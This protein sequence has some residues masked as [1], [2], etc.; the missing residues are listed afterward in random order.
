VRP[1]WI[2]QEDIEGIDSEP[3]IA[4]VVAQGMAVKRFKH[5]TRT[6]IDFSGY[7]PKACILCYGDIDFVHQAYNRAPFVPGVWCNFSNMKCSKYYTYLGEHLLNQQYIIM[8]IGELLR[9]W[10]GLT[11]D[12][13]ETSGI[14]KRS[15][16]VRP[17]SGAKPFTGHIIKYDEYHKIQSLIQ[18]IGPETLVIVAPEKQITAEWRFVICDKKVVTG[19][20]YLPVEC[21]LT[22][23]FIRINQPSSFSLATAIAS[24]EWQP[25]L[26]YTVDIAE[27]EGDVHLLEINSF[28][29][30]G[31]YCCDI[32]SIVRNAS[33]VAAKEWK[34]YYD[35]NE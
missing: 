8:P 11:T 33:E 3:L 31:F 14:F 6:E 30:A 34:D 16:F 1:A 22:H 13:S 10:Y 35:S 23:E 17:D 28:S 12:Y 4:E 24:Q 19:S 27:S 25:D 32:A 20:Q 15:L 18:E 2:I 21:Q 29:C 7:D 5:S 26:C 9:R